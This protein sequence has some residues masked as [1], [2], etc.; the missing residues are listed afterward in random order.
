[1]FGS[2]LFAGGFLLSQPR[3]EVGVDPLGK[4][5]KFVV[6][7]D[8]EANER[9]EIRQDP[10]GGC[11]LNLGL[12]ESGVGLPELGFGPEMWRFLDRV[13]EFFDVFESEALF[14]SFARLFS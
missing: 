9:D 5:N 7:V 6:L 1:M 4:G 8:G 11:A 3:F 13:G 12:I 14:V 10:L 2:E